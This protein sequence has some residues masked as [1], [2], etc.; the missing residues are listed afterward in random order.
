MSN[1]RAAFKY[2]NGNEILK[3]DMIVGEPDSGDKFI[4]TGF[5]GVMPINVPNEDGVGNKI[6]I[7]DYCMV[8]KSVNDNDVTIYYPIQSTETVWSKVVRDGEK[9]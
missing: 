2:G 4:V 8:L 9:G 7:G 1:G 3:G 6:N 5:D